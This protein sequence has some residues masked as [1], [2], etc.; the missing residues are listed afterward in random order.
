LSTTPRDDAT[1]NK[2]GSAR[3]DEEEALFMA[4]LSAEERDFVELQRG[5][6]NSQEAEVAWLEKMEYEYEE[7]DVRAFNFD[8]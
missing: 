1:G 7:V 8:A 6:G 4:C 3:G 2:P 5:L